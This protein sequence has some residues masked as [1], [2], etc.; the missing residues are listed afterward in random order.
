M[1]SRA[2]RARRDAL[3]AFLR[4]A[5][6]DAGW[7]QQK[8]AKRL[9]RPQSFV[10]KYEAGERRLDIIEVQEICNILK[11]PVEKVLRALDRA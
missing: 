4:Q 1:R 5:R 3:Q 11:V 7:T 8:L 2:Y 9:D 10:S 6:L